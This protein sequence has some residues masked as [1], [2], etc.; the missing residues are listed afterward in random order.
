MLNENFMEWL[1]QANLIV[2]AMIIGL[3]VSLDVFVVEVT[4]DYDEDASMGGVWTR[5]MLWMAFWH[6]L[7]HSLSFYLYMM[8][9][10]LLQ[11][12]IFIPI[13]LFDLPD[14]VGRGALT[15]LS[16]IIFCFIWWTYRN[17]IKEDHSQKNDESVD[18][19]RR[20]MRLLVDIIRV[21]ASKLNCGERA[22][23]LV[24]AGSV[25]V[26]MLAISALLKHFLLPQN[27]EQ[28]ISKL[29]GYVPVDCLLFAATVF[30]VVYIMVLIAQATGV[31][32]RNVFRMIFLL[33]LLEPFVVFLL[34]AGTVRL[35]NPISEVDSQSIFSGYEFLV[36]IVFSLLILFSLIV[37]NGLSY[38]SLKET[39]GR[40]S[41]DCGSLNSVKRSSDLTNYFKGIS[42]LFLSASF[43]VFVIIFCL[44]WAYSTGSES[45]HNHLI[46]ATQYIAWAVLFITIVFAYAP[47]KYLDKLETAETSKLSNFTT[48]EP[49]QI[50]LKFLGLCVGLLT[51][52]GFNWVSFHNNWTIQQ[53]MAIEASAIWSLYVLLVWALFSLRCYRFYL[54]SSCG[55]KSRSVN[56]ADF[57][58]IISAIGIAS[59]IVALLA[60]GIVKVLIG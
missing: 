16:F 11:F 52:N 39:Y 42:L 19:E 38:K 57:S 17:K 14:G 33:R 53:R 32:V 7:L 20:D 51:L 6:A 5:R 9:I 13:N 26:D 30:F 47:V 29:P 1:A 31:F 43:A 34:L 28:A 8:S 58:E 12:L 36:D 24:I 40:R 46:E 2:F 27:G 22:R 56:D 3:I 55:M 49:S 60:A 50:L 45:S 15:L 4:R 10:H 48:H 23:G 21:F 25:A 59:S 54:A 41:I 44:A 37:S 18:M 35:L